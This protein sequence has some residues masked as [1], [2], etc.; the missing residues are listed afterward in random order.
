MSHADRLS[1]IEER[2]RAARIARNP[3]TWLALLFFALI[4][5]LPAAAP[6]LRRLF[7]DLANPVYTR[8]SFVELTLAHAFLTGASSLIAAI[9]GIGAAIAVTRRAGRDFLG[10]ANAT[11]AIGQTFPPVAVLALAVPLLGY[12]A[13]PTLL[14]LVLYSI[15]PILETSIAG[16][17]NVPESVREAA[18]GMGFSPLGLLLKVELPLAL[19]LV[20][21]GLRTAV[22][23]NIGTATIGSTVGALSLG[24]PIIEGLSAS[25][26]AYVIEGALVVGLFAILSDRLFEI[27]ERSCRKRSGADLSD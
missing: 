15:L 2:S 17:E 20:I 27:L 22:I 23:I 16:L 3:F 8:A 18:R 11:A 7:P 24:S 12:G 6:L 25:N 5:F 26:Q 4:V 14:A 21:A 9:I 1:Q 19:P 10:L 13:A